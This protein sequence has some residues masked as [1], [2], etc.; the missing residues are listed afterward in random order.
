ML[1]LR[2]K[3]PETKIKRREY[4]APTFLLD[5]LKED[6]SCHQYLRRVV[7]NFLVED[8][9]KAKRFAG[10]CEIKQL[11]NCYCLIISTKSFQK[12]KT[13]SSRQSKYTQSS[14]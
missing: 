1:H 5:Q 6:A 3:S 13:I 4:K 14:C 12:N 8:K 2:S 7:T 9:A 10:K 11:N